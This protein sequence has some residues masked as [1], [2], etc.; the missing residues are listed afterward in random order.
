MGWRRMDKV[1]AIIQV[2]SN[3]I[4]LPGKCYLQ[5]EIIPTWAGKTII[6]CVYAQVQVSKLIDKTIVAMPF[7]DY[8]LAR[9]CV[10]DRV[11]IFLGSET[12]VLDRFYQ[13]AKLIQPDHIVRITADCPLITANI[14]DTVVRAHLE[15]GADYTANRL[16]E[17]MYPDGFDVEVFRF[18]ILEDAAKYAIGEDDREHVTPWIKR[19]ASH[20]HGI[21]CPPELLL[22]KDVKLSVDTQEDY[23]RVLKWYEE[24]KS[25]LK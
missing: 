4:R 11:P 19:W 9:S 24:N 20:C 1:I 12:D 23:N 16:E 25:W 6:E 15:S 5:F 8:N 10:I 2:R 14:I 13:C 17:P 22:W 18:G 21:F 7:N 3:S